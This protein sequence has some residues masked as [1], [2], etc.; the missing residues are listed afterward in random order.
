MKRLNLALLLVCF[1][2][3]AAAQT[4]NPFSLEAAIEYAYQNSYTVK[5][6]QINIADAETQIDER[7]AGALPQVN[8]SAAYTRYLKLPAQA[9]PEPFVQLIAASNGGELPPDFS[10]EVSFFLKNNFTTGVGVNQAIFDGGIFTALEAARDYRSYVQAEVEVARQNVRNQVTTA[11]L[12]PLI[13]EEN[14]EFLQKN[15]DNVSELLRETRALYEAG[16]VEQLDVDRL[17][18]SL[19]NL[20]TEL[21]NLRRQR[22]IALNFLKMS[23]GYPIEEPI[24][25]E[26]D[27]DRL[28]QIA[29]DE[30]I[31]VQERSYR[32]RAEYTVITL[33]EQLNQA[34]IRNIKSGYLPT[35]YGNAGYQWQFQGNT[36]DDAFW[37]E[38]ASIG[39]NLNVPIFD[40]F[41]RRSQIERAQLQ[42][43]LLTNQRK[44]LERS[45][46][47]DVMNARESYRNAAQ[48][49]EF[50]RSNL[51]LANRIYETA[52]IKYKEGV[53]SSIEVQ[54]AEQSL[55]ATQQNY[56]QAAYDLV[57]S[58]SDLDRALGN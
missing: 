6:A 46:D 29:T 56:T 28:L 20:Q 15:I 41:R 32:N 26:D 55:F 5:N 43:Q 18:L 57:V 53:G 21:D 12:G 13:L 47:L 4:G 37:A 31:L 38:T 34:N 8:G 54:Q 17:Q 2:L 9:L 50:Q 45:I 10:R 14:A 3:G 35:L 33:G 49:I 51:E 39:V 1:V 42:A 44:E 58:K 24:T 30:S 52:R 22:K 16:F 36:S 7:R 27:L 25:I 40:G 11:Y 23:M 48:R 19:S